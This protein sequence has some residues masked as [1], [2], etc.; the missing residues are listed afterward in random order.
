MMSVIFDEDLS[1]R[2][3]CSPAAG[4][5]QT[6]YDV[7]TQTTLRVG[8]DCAFDLLWNTADDVIP[9]PDPWEQ[10]PAWLQS[11]FLSPWFRF[12][13][14]QWLWTHAYR[15]H[16]RQPLLPESPELERTGQPRIR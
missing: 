16:V 6:V 1:A 2:C 14:V 12:R 4:G 15:R 3:P 5:L 10:T 13:V 11:V 7:D 8:H 9:L